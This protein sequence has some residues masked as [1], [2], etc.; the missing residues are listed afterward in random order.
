MRGGLAAETEAF[1]DT[2]RSVVTGRYDVRVNVDEE[3]HTTRV[4]AAGR[5]LGEVELEVRRNG[6]EL[7]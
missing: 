1:D 3:A 7:A 6:P 5:L 2:L 4:P